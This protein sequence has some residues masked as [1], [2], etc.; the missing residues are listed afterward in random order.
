VTFAVIRRIDEDRPLR[1][2]IDE[3]SGDV[4]SIGGEHGD[5]ATAGYYLVQPTVLRERN[6]AEAAGFS[7]LRAFF[8]HLHATRYRLAG[9]PMGDSVDVDS[10]PDIIAA[11]TL[12]AG[13]SG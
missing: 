10:P 9:V 11:E 7:A 3:P 2:D 1:I 5:W 4:R 6:A 8:G 12:L 13:T